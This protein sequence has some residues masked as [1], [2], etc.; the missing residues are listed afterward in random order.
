M[1]PSAEPRAELAPLP[2]AD[3]SATYSYG[4]YTVT[5][6]V[7]GPIE[8]GRRDENPF[9]AI[10]DVNV[11][12]AAGVGG[13]AERL[14]ESILQRAL[15]QLIPIRSFPRTMI[16]ITLQVTETPE[17]AYVNTK[18]VQAQLDLAI[19][20]ALLHAAILGLL[21]ASVPLKTVAT[22]VTLAVRAAD[23]H[24]VADPDARTAETARSLHVLGYAAADGGDDADDGELLLAES[25]G[26]FTVVE[27]EAVLK[28][29]EEV[30]CR[31]VRRGLE[32]EDTAMADA[33]EAPSIR[34]F[35]RS[36]METKIAQD[37]SWK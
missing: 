28:K 17:N 18:V 6:A 7:N 33:G 8:A 30:C 14:L 22:A 15:R 13:T 3:G 12:P 4:G 26:A 37:L 2:K 19:I 36:V 5:S 24:V 35:I 20:P 25:Q 31:A 21:T 32:E 27:W 16:Q 9:E 23:G 10:V 11:R 29:G 34:A 1:A